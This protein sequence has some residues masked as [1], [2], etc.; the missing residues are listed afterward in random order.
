[1]RI[2]SFTL[3]F[4]PSHSTGSPELLSRLVRVKE[5]VCE[6]GEREGKVKQQA[7]HK[8]QIKSVKNTF[9]P[10]RVMGQIYTLSFSLLTQITRRKGES[11]EKWYVTC[12][13]IY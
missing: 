6:R 10:S 12:K 3:S 13:V 4:C 5:F 9:L 2:S 7:T 8:S 11:Q 1:M